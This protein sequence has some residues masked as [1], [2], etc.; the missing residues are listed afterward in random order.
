MF[1]V[2]FLSKGKEGNTARTRARA[3]T[4]VRVRTH[5]REERDRKMRK[6][7]QGRNTEWMRVEND[8]KIDYSQ[9]PS[10]Q[11]HTGVYEFGLPPLSSAPKVYQIIE[12]TQAAVG[13]RFKGKYI[14][15]FDPKK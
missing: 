9:H 1:S 15:L 11:R 5:A 12:H 4:H 2:Y 10:G 6:K 3:H 7:N 8:R 14:G 13:L